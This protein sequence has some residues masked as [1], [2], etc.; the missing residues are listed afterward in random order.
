MRKKF[1]MCALVTSVVA[2]AGCGAKPT[3]NPVQTETEVAVE[4]EEIYDSL[5]DSPE[6]SEETEVESEATASELE[7]TDEKETDESTE[8]TE[9]STDEN[10]E[11]SSE[12]SVEE[13]SE[14]EEITSETESLSVDSEI[15]DSGKF[16]D[17][18][19]IDEVTTDDGKVTKSDILIPVKVD[20]EKPRLGIDSNGYM[21]YHNGTHN[22]YDYKG[23]T[24]YKKM[25][26]LYNQFMTL[27]A[28]HSFS[29]ENEDE[30][31]EVINAVNDMWC[32][33]M[34]DFN[35]DRYQDGKPMIV[36]INADVARKNSEAAKEQ[37][38][39]LVEKCKGNLVITEKDNKTRPMT[40][41]EAFKY[42]IDTIVNIVKP[43]DNGEFDNAF[44]ALK[45]GSGTS[46]A[47]AQIY[48]YMGRLLDYDIHYEAGVDDAGN[49]RAY[50]II[51]DEEGK[52]KVVD[53]WSY[54]KTKDVKYFKTDP[55]SYPVHKTIDGAIQCPKMISDTTK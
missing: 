46:T 35:I 1:L 42:Y 37:I 50:N 33:P 15:E 14:V 53:V 23:E 19:N 54:A 26:K 44:D 39:K 55:A 41:E 16:E 36:W 17:D 9:S 20:T 38:K 29:C 21:V 51:Y 10:V 6:E 27:K 22:C 24:H 18:V 40:E 3:D 11:E 43:D 8:E 47:Y 4:T 32:G 48:Q 34:P 52:A 28:G 30:L 12:E 25:K 49:Y 7:E 45:N 31:A 2:L 5:E 13:S